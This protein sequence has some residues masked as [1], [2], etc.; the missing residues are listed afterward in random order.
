MATGPASHL[1]V[2]VF[3]G[4]TGPQLL[5]FLLWGGPTAPLEA[6]EPAVS[7]RSRWE[8]LC[9]SLTVCCGFLLFGLGLGFWLYHRLSSR[10]LNPQVHINVAQQTGFSVPSTSSIDGSADSATPAR[11]H[12]ARSGKGVIEEP[13]A[14]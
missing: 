13:P 5:A 3:V 9:N 8:S 12:I 6:D 11:R 2:A 7:L 1:A 10:W 14:W 4:L